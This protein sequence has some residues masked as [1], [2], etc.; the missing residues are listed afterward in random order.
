MK[1]HYDIHYSQGDWAACLRLS[2][3]FS[4]TPEQASKLASDSQKVR[5]E[6]GTH[7]L[8]GGEIQRRK[9]IDGTHHLLS[10]KIQSEANHTRVVNGTHNFLGPKM[11]KQRV[12]AGTHHLLGPAVNLKRINEGTH[13][14]TKDWKCEHCGKEGKNLA[15]YFRWH[16]NNCKSLK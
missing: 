3:R 10:G 5:V 15:S 14:F 9:V 16:G 4:I 6:N 12:E 11:N 2:S 7:H 13:N 8:L 1:E